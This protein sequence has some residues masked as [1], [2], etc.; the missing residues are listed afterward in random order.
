[1]IPRI[2]HYCWFGESPMPTL[3]EECIATW[4]HY[5]PDWEYRLWNEHTFDVGRYRYTREAYDAGKYAFVSDVARLEALC[6]EGGVYMDVDF[7]VLKPYDDLLDNQAFAGF[8]GSKHLPVMMGVCGS[9]PHSLWVQ[10]MLEC[11]HERR[12]LVDGQPDLT[13]N[14]TY[15]TAVMRQGGLVQN[16]EEQYYK[17]L[18]IYPVDYFCPHQTTGEY[19][20]TEH[21]YGQHLGFNSWG[22]NAKGWKQ[23]LQ[24]VIGQRAMTWL[25]KTKRRLER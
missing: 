12:F 19:L 21:T 3:A 10:E 6:N 4:H 20:R 23:R 13:P 22:G 18:H 17:D 24:K 8:E 9:V 11:Y 25:I 14:T 2:I 15:L 16:G 7:E 1:M 5:M